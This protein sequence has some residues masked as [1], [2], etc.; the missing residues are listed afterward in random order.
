MVLLQHMSF[1]T[2]HLSPASI[3]CTPNIMGG[4]PCI[5]GTRVPAETI[6]A[7]I[8]A[9][10]SVY[11]ILRGYPYLPADAPEAVIEWAH[12]NGRDVSLPL[13]RVP[14]AGFVASRQ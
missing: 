3:S 11:E 1:N 8:N 14:I 10:E 7:C 12:A 9:G 5:H 4:T 13:R 6:L 2:K